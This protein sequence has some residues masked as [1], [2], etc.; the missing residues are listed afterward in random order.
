M[1][2]HSKKVC[3]AEDNLRTELQ[4]GISHIQKELLSEEGKLAKIQQKASREISKSKE[5]LKSFKKKLIEDNS[6]STKRAHE[7]IDA[8]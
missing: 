8:L 3:D 2:E 1:I 7:G 6:S 5:D 4:S